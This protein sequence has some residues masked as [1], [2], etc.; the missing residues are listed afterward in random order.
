MSGYEED[1]EN[2]NKYTSKIK[3][4]HADSSKDNNGDGNC[5]RAG[6]ENGDGNKKRIGIAIE[7]E[8]I[9]VRV[10]FELKNGMQ[11]KADIRLEWK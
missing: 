2:K 9:E 8:L 6:N 4:N 3:E 10:I 1:C 5:I 7:T 11:V